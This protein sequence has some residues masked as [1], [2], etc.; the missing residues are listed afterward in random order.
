ANAS[1]AVRLF[2]E[3]FERERSERLTSIGR[4]LSGVMHDMRTPLTVISG[5]VQLM[6]TTTNAKTRQEHARIILQQFDAISAMQR[7]VLEYARGE[8]TVLVRKVY[9]A[10]FFGDIEK[11]LAPECAEANVDLVV[12]VHDRGTARFDE[13][14]LTRVI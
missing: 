3:R 10:K 12:K 9:L 8:R 6:T 7:E 5:Y 4:L 11:Q 14:K 13:G 2:R 1:T